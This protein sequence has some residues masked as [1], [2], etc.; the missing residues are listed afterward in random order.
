MNSKMYADTLDNA[1]LPTLWQYFG[2]GPFLFQQDNSSIHTSRLAQTW[3]DEMGVRKLDW[4]SKSHD[5]NPIEHISDEL[6]RRLCSEPNRP[7]SLQALTS[8]V[9]DAWNAVPMVTYEKFV[10]SLPKRVQAAIN[11]KGGP[12]SY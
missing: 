5:L 4:P 6:E 1:A 2:E 7:S 12:T 3:F 8:P 9:M 10:E 11:A